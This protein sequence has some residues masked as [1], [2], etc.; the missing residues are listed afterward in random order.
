MNAEQ[1]TDDVRTPRAQLGSSPQ[2]LLAT[3]LGEYLDSADA[4]LP[5]AAV[6]AMLR[7]FGITEPSARAALSRLVKRGLIAARGNTRPPVYHLTPAAIARHRSRMRHFLDFGARPPHWTGDWVVV[8][9]SVPSSGQAARHAVR[10]ALTGHGFVGLYDSV[11]IRPGSHA[12][13][14]REELTALLHAVEGARW[15]VLH[16]RFDEESGPHGPA[17]AYDLTGLAAGYTAFVARYAPLRAAARRGSVDPAT[18][19]VA[20]T[21]AMDS[22]RRFADTDP[23]LPAH[24]LPQPWPRQQARETFLDVHGALGALARARLV[25]VA[26]P[27]WPAAAG[28]I[29]HFDATR[30]AT[31]PEPADGP[32]GVPR[33]TG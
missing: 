32:P 12:G 1:P 16:A 20:R 14:V 29:T 22:W 27:H 9:F 6:I 24:L 5:S 17:A 19:L 10:R 15:S 28:W 3:L 13:P 25:E 33:R 31:R 21:S 18:A 7:E 23:D 11:W 8:S 30:D 4:D 2:H 26:A